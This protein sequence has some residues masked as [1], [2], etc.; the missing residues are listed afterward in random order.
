MSSDPLDMV[1]GSDSSVQRDEAESTKLYEQALGL[2]KQALPNC[3]YPLVRRPVH[4]IEV[5]A[6]SS[7]RIGDAFNRADLLASAFWTQAEPL[8]LCR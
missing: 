1:I 5:F 7:A 8:L 3:P 6:R 2:L 4:L